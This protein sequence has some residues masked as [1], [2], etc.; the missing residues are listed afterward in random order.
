ML[1]KP[2]NPLPA[3]QVG[4]QWSVV[5][6]SGARF[7]MLKPGILRGSAA[8]SNPDCANNVTRKN[9]IKGPFNSGL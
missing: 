7:T 3:H 9:S 1:L 4:E 6:P 2:I 5:L 8:M